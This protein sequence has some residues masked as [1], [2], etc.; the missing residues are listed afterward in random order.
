MNAAVN[1]AVARLRNEVQAKY[2]DVA[3]TPSMGFHFHV[4]R[5]HVEI[6]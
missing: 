2:A 5:P 1:A 3:T 6:P 4:G